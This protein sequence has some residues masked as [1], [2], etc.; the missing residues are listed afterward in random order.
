MKGMKIMKEKVVPI[1]GG[2]N[3]IK[4][5]NRSAIALA[6]AVSGMLREMNNHPIFKAD[7]LV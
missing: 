7:R 6:I 1:L 4:S 5:N 3:D 2:T